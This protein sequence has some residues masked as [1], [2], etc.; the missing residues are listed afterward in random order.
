MLQFLRDFP[1]VLA[2]FRR[3]NGRRK[4]LA[5]HA[6]GTTQRF[7][8]HAVAAADLLHH[9]QQAYTQ[10]LLAAIPGRGASKEPLKRLV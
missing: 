10:Q 5:I 1:I 4:N 8:T 6:D 7:Q 9:P 2:N 3:P